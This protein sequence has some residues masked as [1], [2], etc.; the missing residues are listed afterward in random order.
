M[1][2]FNLLFLSFL[3]LTGC[4]YHWVNDI[5]RKSISIPYIEG[6]LEG[7]LTSEVISAINSSSHFQ[8]KTHSDLILKGRIIKNLDQDIGFKEEQDGTEEERSLIAVEGRKTFTVEIVLCQNEKAIWGPKNIEAFVDYDYVDPH[9][10]SDLSFILDGERVSIL[11]FSLGQL[12]SQDSAQD[13]ALRPLYKK[14][15]QKIVDV[16]SLEW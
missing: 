9:S 11:P 7:G 16:I 3:T 13:G 14:L 8:F 2:F 12:S 1:R 10:L 6:D 15:A 5:P 4:G